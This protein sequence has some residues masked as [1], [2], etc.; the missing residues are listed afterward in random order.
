LDHKIDSSVDRLDKKIEN[1]ALGLVKTQADVQEIKK[2][3]ATKDD[4]NLILDRID[5]FTK[6]VD[7]Y[8]KKAIIQDYRLNQAESGLSDHEKRLSSLEARA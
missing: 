6:R 3:M 1:V 2:T 7:V 4:V 8:D 5:S